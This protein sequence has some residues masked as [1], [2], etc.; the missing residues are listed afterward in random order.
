MRIFARATCVLGAAFLLTLAAAAVKA[1]EAAGSATAQTQAAIAVTSPAS[2]PVSPVQTNAVQ[3]ATKVWTNDDLSS[4][5]GDGAVSTVSGKKAKGNTKPAP[6]APKTKSAAPYRDQ[7]NKLEAQ[8]PPID[9]QIADL[10]AALSG[11]TSSAPRKFVGVKPDD[12]QSELNQL[13]AKRA[14]LESQI[15]AIRDQARHNGVPA[16]ALP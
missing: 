4:L 15:Q 16:N 8:L 3:P 9:S 10:Q 1:Q 7:I 11:Q 13:Q 2:A 6:A 12:W 14:N 5:H